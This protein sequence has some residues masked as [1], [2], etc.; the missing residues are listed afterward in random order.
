[1][2]NELSMTPINEHF[3]DGRSFLK[4]Q[5]TL[6]KSSL[7]KS[8]VAGMLATVFLLIQ[9]TSFSF[10]AH[11][12]MINDVPFSSQWDLLLCFAVSVV[13]RMC[14][15]RLQSYYAQK[16]SLNARNS[17]RQ[18]MLS[19]W[20][21]SSP[22]T[23]HS[24]SAGALATQWV[25]EVEA[26]DGYFS[27]YWPQ[28]MLALISPLLILCVVTYINWVCGLLLL[29]AAPLIPM[30]MILVGMGA[31]KL[32]QKYS[33]VRQRL[34]G[35][36]L[37]RVANLTTIKLLGAQH[38]VFVEV[39]QR[40]QNYRE[41][42]MKTL[43]VAFLSSTVLEFFTSVAIASLAIYIGFSL[44]GAIAW[45]PAASLS[46]ATGLAIL[47]LAPEFFQPMRNLSQYYH[48]RATALGAAENL[49][50]SLNTLV[51]SGYM[52]NVNDV[53]DVNDVDGANAQQSKTTALSDQVVESVLK[54]DDVNK[55]HEET[56][57]Q[58]DKA[59]QHIPELPSSQLTCLE[60]S[61]LLIGHAQQPLLS[62]P[63]NICARTGELVVISGKSGTGKSTLL[64]TIAGFMRPLQGS[65]KIN[66]NTLGKHTY[67]PQRAWIKNDT[68][69]N[70]LVVLAPNAS[71]KQMI[72]ALNIVGLQDELMRNNKGL[73]TMLGE[74]GQGLSGGQM[75]RIALAR[76]LLD[77]SPLILL[78][79]PS[80]KLDLRS[81]QYVIDAIK[82]LKERA[83]IV[84][85]THDPALI[86]IA[87]QHINLDL[88]LSPNLSSNLSPNLS[89]SAKRQQQ[90][91][92]QQ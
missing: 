31:E 59:N 73:N 88:I 69:F 86:S 53:N 20:R 51:E 16:A 68:L 63:F 52:D 35:H 8:V 10:T 32:N 39:A 36:F 46:L 41:V 70:N 38:Q 26:M 25:E 82:R 58:G 56:K 60:L 76:V 90:A 11:Q 18:L 65:V 66:G 74:H 54:F 67:L 85:A 78:D 33:V 4:R 80:A 7:Y 92:Q 72:E 21:K 12:I 37:D 28:Q 13:A 77:P 5:V 48:D 17:I 6:Q 22:L 84:I 55:T 30:F 2:Q 19:C 44:Y 45:G 81:K 14:L 79:E 61:D 89:L 87:N 29:I 57:L 43:K 62:M 71:H 91:M 42:I 24:Y 49:A 64:N 83:I 1:M 23:L 3:V 50:S 34:A 15:L 47:I 40:S 9:W 75:Q 27:R